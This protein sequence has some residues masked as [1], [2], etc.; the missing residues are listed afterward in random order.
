MISLIFASLGASLIQSH[1]P[2]LHPST[3]RKNRAIV[4]TICEERDATQPAS[5]RYGE[6][7]HSGSHLLRTKLGQKIKKR[8]RIARATKNTWQTSKKH[9]VCAQMDQIYAPLAATMAAASFAIF[10]C[11]T[12][13]ISFVKMSNLYTT[14]PCF[15]KSRNHFGWITTCV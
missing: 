11:F 2:H 6:R 13:T 10:S 1:C 14:L 5:R 3:P 15:R 4:S 12:S 8:D 9:N 7:D